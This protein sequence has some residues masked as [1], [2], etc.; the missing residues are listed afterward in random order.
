MTVKGGIA[1]PA[2][3]EAFIKLVLGLVLAAIFLAVGWLA[4]EA[5][6]KTLV[7]DVANPVTGAGLGTL[8]AGVAIGIGIVV[9]AT[10]LSLKK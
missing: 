4:F 3:V 10:I 5:I 6:A 7:A 1:L 8:A 9:G 2:V